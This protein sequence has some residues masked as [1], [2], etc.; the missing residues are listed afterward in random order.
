MSQSLTSLLCD[1]E[2]LQQAGLLMYTNNPENKNLLEFTAKMNVF[3]SLLTNLDPN[4]RN[5]V[6]KAKILAKVVERIN[7]FKGENGGQ[8]PSDEWLKQVIEEEF[9]LN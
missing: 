2:F 8:S 4:K 6:R 1:K 7:K 3:S 5:Q 9:R